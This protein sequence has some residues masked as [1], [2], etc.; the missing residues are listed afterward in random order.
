[1]NINT[2]HAQARKQQ[3]GISELMEELIRVFG[4]DHYQKGGCVLSYIPEKKLS[5]I[6]CALDKLSKVALIKDST[7]KG[8]TFMHMNQRIPKTS[9][10]S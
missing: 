8:I 6:R 9:Y 1:M 7:E 4:E 2:R 5:Q 10:K 3:R